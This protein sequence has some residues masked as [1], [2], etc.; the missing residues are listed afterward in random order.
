MDR[1]ACNA[2]ESASDFRD[3]IVGDDSQ[4]HRGDGRVDVFVDFNER[5]LTTIIVVSELIENFY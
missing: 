4:V 1:S 5:L 2:R 3:N